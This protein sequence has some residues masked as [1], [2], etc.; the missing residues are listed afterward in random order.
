MPWN[1]D[2]IKEDTRRTWQK[3][4]GEGIWEGARS[5]TSE[6]NTEKE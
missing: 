1:L 2:E 4:D 3:N 6:K 5:E